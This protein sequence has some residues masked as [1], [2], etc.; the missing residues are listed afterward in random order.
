[1]KTKK[2]VV[3]CCGLLLIFSALL[4]FL[5]VSNLCTWNYPKKESLVYE[6]CTFV[7]Y[8][9]KSGRSSRYYIYVREYEEPLEIDNIVFHDVNKGDLDS[10]RVGGK[11][12]I[13]KD[14]HLTLYSL[15][16]HGESILSYDDYLQRHN[17]NHIIGIFVTLIFN[18]VTLTLFVVTI[19]YYKKTGKNL[20]CI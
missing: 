12:K 13:A 2:S 9:K 6:R 5:F 10:I 8:E 15:E 19:I 3:I 18:G 20:F 7:K 16:Y 17:K 1:M 11:I 4:L 14:K